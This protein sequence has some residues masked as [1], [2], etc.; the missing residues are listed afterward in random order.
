MVVIIKCYLIGTCFKGQ[1]DIFSLD[2]L[3]T[4]SC[5]QMVL[6]FVQFLQ[7]QLF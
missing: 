6:L 1:T 3:P 2:N 7:K 4:P 5:F